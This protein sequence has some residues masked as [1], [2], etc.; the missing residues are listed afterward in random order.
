[1]VCLRGGAGGIFDALD[2]HR[3]GKR[4]MQDEMLDKL[5]AN[6]HFHHQNAVNNEPSWKALQFA[7]RFNIQFLI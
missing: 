1:M 6:E 3:E 7:L 2:V 4:G 5:P